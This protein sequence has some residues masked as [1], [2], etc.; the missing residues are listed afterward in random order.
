M[1]QKG[2]CIQVKRNPTK[3]IISYI[4]L[5]ITT[6]VYLIPFYIV[7]IT[8]FKSSNEIATQNPFI[9][10]PSGDQLGFSGYIDIFESYTIFGTGESMILVGLKNTLI[11]MI[12]VIIVGMFSSSIAAYA[13]AKLKFKGKKIMFSILMFSMMLPSIILLIPSY[14][15]YDNLG[16][17]VSFPFFPLMIPPM[18]GSAT[19]VFFLKGYYESIP[20]EL[21]DSAKMD[22]LGY[23]KTYLKVILP[24]A[25]PA[26]IAQGLLG[27]VAVYNDYLLPLIY[28]VNEKDYTLQIALQMFST[29]NNNNLP[30]VMAGAVISILPILILYFCLQK[31]FISGLTTSGIKR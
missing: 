7:L 20:N 12:P 30:T 26:I 24:L 25:K 9:W 16:L 6:L 29:G 21:L 15:M 27:V 13:Y 1:F 8:S 23:F 31:Y 11:I 28:L 2:G 3:K 22:G 5:I 17:T 18:F 10:F 4:V 19:C 14:F